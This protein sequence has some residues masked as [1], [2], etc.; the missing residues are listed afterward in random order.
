LKYGFLLLFLVF[1]SSCANTDNKAVKGL[2]LSEAIEQSAEKTAKELPKNSRVAVV[3]FDSG[4]DKF[5]EFIME[6][7]NGALLDRGVKV[8]DRKNLAHVFQELNFQTSGN[9]NEETAL[10][11]GK[12]LGA[13]IVITGQL[14]SFENSYRYRISAINVETAARVSITRL[15]VRNDREI[16]QRQQNSNNVF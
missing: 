6:K 3:A 2:S 11:V 9:V 8:V 4:N 5:S 10:S 13:D 1:L 15:D 7:L 14:N 16:D 12:F